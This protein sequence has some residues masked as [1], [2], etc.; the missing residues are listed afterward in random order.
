MNKDSSIFLAG[1]KGLVGSSVLNDLKSQGF[2]KIITIDKKKV[3]L[4]DYDKILNYF[5]NRN[6]DYMIMA[7]AR[8]GGILANSKFQKDFFF[9]NI[10]IQNNLLKLALKKK[11][12]R[13]IYLGTSCIYPKFSKNPIK[14]DYLLT[15]K[16]E[17]TNQCYAIAKIAGIILSEALFNDHK[18][19]VV[20]LMPTNI[21]GVNDN[22]DKFSGHVIPAMIN[23]IN[24]AKRLK[25]KSVK[26]LGTGKPIREFLFADDLAKAILLVLR[27]KKKTINKVCKKQFPLI[28]VGSGESISIKNL[29]KKIAKI[30][31]YK[32]KII[33]DDRFPDGTM[34]KNL[35]SKLIN[36]LGWHPITSLNKG[37]RIS[38][39]NYIKNR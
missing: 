13:T 17:K 33:F 8:A 38:I 3:D 30:S 24:E 26:L 28:N 37:L 9:E 27:S 12:K 29:S 19:D 31:N 22:F 14:E 4:R 34:K 18:L 25:R 11:I 7:A 23:K 1:H 32:G 2:K 6:I 10:E 39:D 20:C 5:K 36:A 21:Y 35:N 16:L 15:G